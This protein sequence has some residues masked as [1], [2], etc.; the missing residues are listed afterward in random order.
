MAM[1]AITGAS[2]FIGRQLDRCARAADHE[3]LVLDR[4]ALVGGNFQGLERADA[5]LHLAGLAHVLGKQH[6]DPAAFFAAN[7]QLTQRVFGAALSAGVHRFIYMSSAGV[8][9]TTSPPEGF[10]EDTP[11][12]PSEAYARSKLE[13][14]DWLRS[15]EAGTEVVVVRPPLVYGPGAP[16]N[17]GRLLKITAS[18]W[19][20]PLGG[21]RAERSMI[22][23]RNLCDLLLNLVTAPR[24]PQGPVLV[25]DGEDISLRDL[26]IRLR[27]LRGRAPGII[28]VPAAAVA[29]LL[30]AAGRAREIP[31]ITQPFILRPRQTAEVMGWRP[32]YSLQEELQWSLA[33][34][35]DAR[36]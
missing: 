31:K 10:T 1:L 26:A 36:T 29:T 20:L 2:G 22:G 32:P 27:T 33:A 12:K 34:G 5:L 3:V 16:G 25:S 21:L 4:A 15:Q 30:R 6:S 17:F 35:S 24:V 11:A 28:N 9:G 19:P 18:R 7:V 8:L 23:L 13:A 14:E